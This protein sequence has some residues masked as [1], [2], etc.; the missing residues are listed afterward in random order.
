MQVQLP[1]RRNKDQIG[2]P[3]PLRL[4]PCLQIA[5]VGAGLVLPSVAAE[6]GN[7][8]ATLSLQN[9]R[10]KEGRKEGRRAADRCVLMG[11]R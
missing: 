5:R 10:S 7:A 3:E 2:K 8:T 9:R 11:M 4:E 1:R 6:L